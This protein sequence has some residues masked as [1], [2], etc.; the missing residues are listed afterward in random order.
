MCSHCSAPGESA[1]LALSTVVGTCSGTARR[2]IIGMEDPNR[3]LD[4]LKTA[5]V[6]AYAA[7][8]KEQLRAE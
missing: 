4:A 1:A 5:M 8:D 2:R 6:R 3:R 7:R